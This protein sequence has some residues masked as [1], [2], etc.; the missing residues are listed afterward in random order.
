M[1]KATG[2]KAYKIG[3][4]DAI[5]DVTFDDGSTSAVYPGNDDAPGG[6]GKP[7]VYHF[8]FAMKME[9]NKPDVWKLTQF[10]VTSE[11]I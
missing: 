8:R 10:V 11:N 6:I 5:Y 2:A 1:F 7:A 9:P 4:D 3:Y